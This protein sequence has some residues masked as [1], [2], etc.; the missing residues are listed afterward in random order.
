MNKKRIMV[1]MSATLLHHG[2]IRLLQHAATYGKVVVGLTA[3]D[4]IEKKKGYVPELS[5]D[6]RK[7]ILESI[8]VVTEVV[9]VPWKITEDI[10]TKF[11]I[12]L[13]VHGDDNQN[14]ISS[15]KLIIIP[16]TKGVNSSDLR[17]KASNNLLKIR[18]KNKLMLTPGPAQLPP[19]VIENFFPVF[20]RG[21][22]QYE[23]IA[24]KTFSWIKSIAGQDSLMCA[25]GSSTFSIELAAHTFLGGKLLLISNGYY[26]DRLEHLAPSATHITKITPDEIHSIN[27]KFDWI[28]FAYTETSIG[29]KNDIEAIHKVAKE[30]DAKLFV[31]ATASIG[32]EPDHHLA[33]VICFSS[34]KGLFGLT[35]AS[36][37]SYNKSIEMKKNNSFYFN[38]ETQI[39]KKVTGP[40]HAI[41]SLYGVMPQHN[42]YRSRVQQSKDL[43]LKSMSLFIDSP[44]HQPLLCTQVQGKIIK[45]DDNVVLYQPRS[46]IAGSV[47]CHLGEID[48]ENPEILDRIQII[49][50]DA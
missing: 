1:D 17:L 4:E 21:D 19:Q 32:L 25:Q 35:G 41:C 15:E 27:E 13:L 24:K 10:L 34:C 44:T 16:R 28:L 11:K 22:D 43:I 39:D 47:I 9:S 2:H 5:Y 50:L 18:N 42:L 37:I 48:K 33:D 3:D 45:N 38:I 30:I 46:S 6:Q 12:D 7:E 29:Y 20:G 14:V 8:S 26:A 36:F 23:K 49:G 40:Y 31:D